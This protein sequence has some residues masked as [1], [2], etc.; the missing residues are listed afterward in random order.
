M[1]KLKMALVG[2]LALVSS[3]AFADQNTNTTQTTY[4]YDATNARAGINTATPRAALEVS[5]ATAGTNVLLI[6]PSAITPTA[7]VTGS[8]VLNSNGILC[9]ISNT[10]TG[11]WSKVNGNTACNFAPAN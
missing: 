7:T 8:L 2:A 9:F 3:V 10:T 1:N 5:G 6:A 11:A 4:N